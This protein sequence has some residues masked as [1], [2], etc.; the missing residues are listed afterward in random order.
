[1]NE[2]T[3]EWWKRSV[4]NFIESESDGIDMDGIWIVI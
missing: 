2:N 3:H 1:M 4:K